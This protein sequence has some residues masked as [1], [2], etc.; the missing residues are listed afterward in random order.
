MLE[1]KKWTFQECALNLEQKIKDNRDIL[2][3]CFI[4]LMMGDFRN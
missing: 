4:F 3:F 1:Q 2:N